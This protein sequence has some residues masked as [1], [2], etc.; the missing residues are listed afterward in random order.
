APPSVSLTPDRPGEKY[1]VGQNVAM[2]ANASGYNT[3]DQ[4]YPIGGNDVKW[5]IVLHHCPSGVGSGCHIHPSTPTPQP[6]GNTFGMTVPNPGAL[7]FRGFGATPTAAEGLSPT[8]SFT[9]PMDFRTIFLSSTQ[10]GVTLTVNASVLQTPGSAT[11]VTNSNNLLLA[12]ESANGVPFSQWSDG[13]TNRTKQFIMPASD[14]ALAACDGVPCSPPRTT[15][16]R[17]ARP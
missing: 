7:A 2:T 10:P 9:L 6:T 11:A 5:D 12:P 1:A 15:P 16:P 13:D 17:P 3:A 8:P 4:P 14:M